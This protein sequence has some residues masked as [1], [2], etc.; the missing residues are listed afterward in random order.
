MVMFM[1]RQFSSLR[2]M[3]H[4]TRKLGV[5]G[6][7]TSA[8]LSTKQSSKAENTG[9]QTSYKRNK[10]STTEKNTQSGATLLDDPVLTITD[11]IS[12]RRLFKLKDCCLWQK[13]RPLVS[14]N[15]NRRLTATSIMT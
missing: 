10:S 13:S 7:R 12:S 15:H 1:F 5:R 9:H 2:T 8:A 3:L 14:G 6:W 11:L 4:L